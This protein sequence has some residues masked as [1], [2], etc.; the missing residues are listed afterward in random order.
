MVLCK[1]C[2]V[3]SGADGKCRHCGMKEMSVGGVT[4]EIKISP[5]KTK[6]EKEKKT[7]KKLSESEL[8]EDEEGVNGFSGI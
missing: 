2:N 7:I 3:E 6:K 4:P 5:L 1:K 8:D